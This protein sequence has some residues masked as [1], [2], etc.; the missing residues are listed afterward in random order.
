MSLISN[1]QKNAIEAVLDHMMDDFGSVCT[2]IHKPKTI[3]CPDCLL[4]A[5]N[6]MDSHGLH[7]GPMSVDNM[8]ICVMCGGSRKI[9][10]ESSENINLVINWYPKDFITV[11]PKV[12]L[13]FGYI[14]SRG[15]IEDLQKIVNCLSMRISLPVN[16]QITANYQLFGEPWDQFNIVKGQC[17]IARWIRSS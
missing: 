9:Q 13:P 3:D 15:N 12:V 14:I 6:T 8:G 10:Q 11:A 16:Q 5:N 2:L 4:L 17:F 7:G 1:K